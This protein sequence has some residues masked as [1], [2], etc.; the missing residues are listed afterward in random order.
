MSLYYCQFPPVTLQDVFS[1][2]VGEVIDGG[3]RKKG[4]LGHSKPTFAFC[5]GT[6]QMSLKMPSC[7]KHAL[8]EIGPTIQI[9]I[10][11]HHWA[12]I[13]DHGVFYHWAHWGSPMT[14]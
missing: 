3:E 5:H 6:G 8:D 2:H 1:T 12:K 14:Y 11:L 7:Q 4:G 13:Y 10:S 9:Y